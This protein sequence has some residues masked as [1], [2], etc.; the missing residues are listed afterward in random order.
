MRLHDRLCLN[1]D[2]LRSGGQLTHVRLGHHETRCWNAA[3]RASTV[4]EPYFLGSPAARGA[5]G[6][7]L[8]ATE[9]YTAC[10]LSSSRCRELRNT[11]HVA[12]GIVSGLAPFVNRR[13]GDVLTYALEMS[14]SI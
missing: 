13:G 3:I 12:A 10:S 5:T 9:P 4:I 11:L 14:S 6:L 8:T 1:T 7:K 2:R